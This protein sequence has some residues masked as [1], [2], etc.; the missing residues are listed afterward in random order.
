MNVCAIMA[1]PWQCWQSVSSI[2]F[3][4][5]FIRGMKMYI[6]R[7]KENVF[8]LREK[9]T[10]FSPS[11]LVCIALHCFALHC[12][13][14]HTLPKTGCYLFSRLPVLGNP[15][16]IQPPFLLLRTK[17]HPHPPKILRRTWETLEHKMF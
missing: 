15:P 10:Y 14:L 5:I 4:P 3:S 11:S 1:L 17:S 9:K 7:S 16:K 8:L 13:A 12:I 6:S 2:T